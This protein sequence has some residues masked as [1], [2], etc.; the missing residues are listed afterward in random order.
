[1]RKELFATVFILS[2]ILLYA[3]CSSSTV[4]KK[5]ET[6]QRQI[7]KEEIVKPTL[8]ET[9]ASLKSDVKAKSIPFSL[10]AR[11]KIDTIIVDDSSKTF[12]INFSK[13]LSYL[14]FRVDNVKEM[15]DFIKIYFGTDYKN[16]NFKI[17]T[18][19]KPIE[20][21]IPNY[22]Q[23]D[24]ERI[25]KSKLPHR[26]ISDRIPVVS[27]ITKPY[28]L[29]NGLQNKN[30]I[31]WNSHG[32][33]Y[34]V[35][36]DRWLWQRP[37][38]F[39]SVEDLIPT[40][41]VLPYLLPMLENAGANVFLPRERD[42][43]TNEV[44]VDNDTP[45]DDKIKSKYQE[46]NLDR[47]HK[48][49][50]FSSK[51]FAYGNPPYAEGYNPF[52]KGT[53]S[54]TTV[55]KTVTAQVSWQ[56]DIPETGYY[57][58][59]VSYN[60][61]EQN[62]SDAHYTVY[63]TGGK[64]EFHVNQKIGGNTW[65]Y[66]GTFKFKNGISPTQACVILDNVSGEDESKI[67]SADAVRFGGGM[68][69]VSRNG[70]TSGRPKFLEGARY[71]LQYAGMPDTLI[72][73]LN[74]NKN[75]YNDDYMC[76][77]EYG[78]YLFG[79]PFG[80][81]KDRAQ[82][83]L[84]IPIDLS[85]AFHTDAGITRNDSVIGTLSI[86]TINDDKGSG[87]FPD[88][89][90]RWANRDFADI[91]QTQIVEDLKAKYDTS[92]VRR[93][94][95]EAD[96]SESRRPNV[97]S[98]LLELLS[99]QNFLDMKFVLDPRF[100]FDVSRAI[101]KS[102]LRFLSAQYNFEYTVQPLPVDHFQAL[103]DNKGGVNL[104]WQPV[105]DKLE[106][107][108]VAQ[109]YVVY[110]RLD[111][112][113]FDNGVL[114]D[115][116]EYFLSSLKPGKIYSFKV[117]AV[118][119]GG[120]SFPSEIL[121]VCWM[122]NKKEPVLIVNGFDRICGPSSVDTKDFAGFTNFLDAGVPDKYDI[123]FIGLQKDFYPNS[124]FITNDSPG[125]GASYADDETQIF[126]GNTFDYPYVHGKSFKNN[127]YSFSSSSDEAVWENQVNI[128]QF[129]LVDLILGEEKE[130]S[131]QKPDGDL[132]NGKQ[133]KTFPQELQAVLK[134]YT[135]KGG[136]LFISGA[137]VAT[138]LFTGRDSIDIAFAK[139][140]LKI[141]FGAD[142]ASKI[143]KV[144]STGNDFIGKNMTFLF[145]TELKKDIYTV[146]A[147][148]GILPANGSKIILRYFENKCPAATA[149][150]KDYGVIVFGFPFETINT[151]EIKDVIIKNILEYVGM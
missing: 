18:L 48:W 116:P 68:G 141:N 37:R 12:K 39:Q 90:S 15:Y 149:Y 14:P 25:D 22:F 7:D 9:I 100:R 128:S 79:A 135:S 97:P 143:G 4:I 125:W 88:S 57:A 52:E 138:D 132:I 127:N 117:T 77:A 148:D 91:L 83:G 122:N 113:D 27:N 3:G 47:K 64:T 36:E 105:N 53:S 85:L 56:P 5:E 33:Y 119:D 28:S 92:W 86:Y 114:V 19:D 139:D 62:V 133:F 146:E 34:S 96:Y 71:Y 41:F 54:Y 82:K 111:D 11:T 13:E 49:N 94:L 93:Q 123:N 23:S 102:M 95:M 29:S 24:K 131:W 66:L 103:I 32:W 118:N 151:Q 99:H 6:Q 30:I 31:L 147:P 67:I 58:V 80:P 136:N 112:N 109:K 46:E 20:E 120:E 126:A 89:S 50:S 16:Y 108:A 63:H 40:S 17:N 137:Y 144:V 43:Q 44:V 101:Y 121:S 10:P 76:R 98:A 69:L 38:L 35:D 110:T 73:N 65:V 8:E 26:K 74:K 60:A 2:C 107:T 70:S 87:K 75:D 61:S 51:G 45:S 81:N 21:L 134:D 72:F 84:G 1:M 106:L 78:N 142:H 55:S 129:K 42:T 104:K 140:V 115:K 150:K 124:K 130:T 145:N 59:Y